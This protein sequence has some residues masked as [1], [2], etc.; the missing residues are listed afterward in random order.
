MPPQDQ[1]TRSHTCRPGAL[2]SL[3]P[4]ARA[5]LVP[6]P[7]PRSPAA[8]AQRR[9]DGRRG[10]RGNASALSAAGFK[11]QRRGPVPLSPAPGI[12][13]WSEAGTSPHP[14]AQAWLD[15]GPRIPPHHVQAAVF[16]QPLAHPLRGR[17]VAEGRHLRG[18]DR[19]LRRRRAARSCAGSGGALP[20][21]KAGALLPSGSPPVRP[22]HTCG[23]TPPCRPP[24]RPSFFSSLQWPGQ[25]AG[26]GEAGMGEFPKRVRPRSPQRGSGKGGRP[27]PAPR[28]RGLCRYPRCPR[29]HRPPAP[30]RERHWSPTRDALPLLIPSSHGLL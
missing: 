16:L 29:P 21:A 30:P 11:R 26:G 2:R 6:H 19:L 3:S 18:L 10:R 25:S 12:T 28:S 23:Q 8:A 24:A 1:H 17:E 27:A 9:S 13:P 20:A 4:C 15:L 14:A 7:A 22:S 5:P